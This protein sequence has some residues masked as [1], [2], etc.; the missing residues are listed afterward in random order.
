MPSDFGPP[1]RADI[2]GSLLRPQALKDA[3]DRRDRG[4][5]GAGELRAIED[6]FIRDA[7]ALQEE[8]GLDAVTDGEFRRR[9][10]HTDFL[11]AI[12]GIEVKGEISVRF[13]NEKGETE[14]RPRNLVVAGKLRHPAGGIQVEDFEFLK[15][16]TRRTPKVCIPGPGYVY[17][18]GGWGAIAGAYRDKEEFFADI[19]QV[20]RDE[21]AALATAGCTYVQIDDTNFSHAC[22]P[23]FQERY[24]SLGED[25]D[26]MPHIFARMINDVARGRPEGMTLCLHMCHGNYRSS[27]ASLGDYERVA[28]AVFTETGVDG[29]FLEY[30]SP[31]TGDFA[32]LRHVPAGKTVVLGLVT[33]K[34][35]ALES[36]DDVKRRIEAASRHVPMD[37]LGL[38][39]QC[40]FASTI[41][42]NALTADD[43]RAKLRLVVEV[44][45]EMWG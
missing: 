36:K 4:E 13:Q 7:V 28:E 20:Y 45:E 38:S 32:P 9:Q 22:D 3:R 24:R 42:G 14:Y 17:G 1:F 21:L 15:S 18:R 5:I 39:P 41:E 11:G 27:W 44:A 25:A 33:T 30:D 10:F 8:V 26:E 2:V 16:V 6:G 12:G 40:G 35:P 37:N 19:A 29:F 31:R 43:Q 23:R 34:H